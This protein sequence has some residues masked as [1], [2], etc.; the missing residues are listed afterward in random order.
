MHA[1]KPYTF[2]YWA[3]LGVHLLLLKCSMNKH[4][5]M[6]IM[7]GNLLPIRLQS[8]KQQSQ[9]IY[10]QD[11]TLIDIILKNINQI[12]FQCLCL[13]RVTPSQGFM[14]TSDQPQP[15]TIVNY[16]PSIIKTEN[17]YS[18]KLCSPKLQ[19]HKV[20]HFRIFIK[21]F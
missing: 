8:C 1:N 21:L 20:N 5:M 3:D 2:D 16:M 9:S 17:F 11:K 13:F 12:I 19:L 6:I 10:L 15:S 18:V 4:S 7:N 14:H